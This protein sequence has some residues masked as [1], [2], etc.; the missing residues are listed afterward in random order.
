VESLAPQSA[1]Q[2]QDF[3]LQTIS[4]QL[5]L[6]VARA[7]VVAELERRYIEHS[8]ERHGGNVAEAA[9]ASGVARRYFQLLRSGKRRQ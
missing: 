6:P 9:K 2:S 5:P 7:R 3:L 4:E 1:S 8:L